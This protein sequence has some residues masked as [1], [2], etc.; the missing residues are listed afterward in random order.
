MSTSPTFA[1]AKSY[2]L[3]AASSWPG[4]RLPQ[5]RVLGPQVAP[6]FLDDYRVARPST[7]GGVRVVALGPQRVPLPLGL[8]QLGLALH[9]RERGP[10]PLRDQG[11]AVVTHRALHTF[12][13]RPDGVRRS[14]AS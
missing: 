1:L 4:Q 3:S 14:P 5:P 8:R 13:T 2:S 11:V 10:V 12:A 7:D 9:Q 6:R